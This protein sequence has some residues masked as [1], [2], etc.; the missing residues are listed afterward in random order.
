MTLSRS[1]CII[2]YSPFFFDPPS[3]A[4]GHMILTRA[5]PIRMAVSPGHANGLFPVNA[6]DNKL[7][8]TSLSC[9]KTHWVA[10]DPRSN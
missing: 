6:D 10:P 2:S 3:L 8:N 9:Q 5:P 7:C 4:K 1:L